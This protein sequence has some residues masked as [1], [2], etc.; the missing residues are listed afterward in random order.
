[1]SER[2]N[3]PGIEPDAELSATLKAREWNVVFAALQEMP[4]RVAAP[5][6]GT[7]GQQLN[8]AG[9][10]KTEMRPNGASE[11]VRPPPAANGASVSKD[12]YAE[13]RPKGQDRE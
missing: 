2:L 7:L 3:A 5:I 13:E 4:F 12:S 9:K 11:P 1:M 8:A 6:L 10:V